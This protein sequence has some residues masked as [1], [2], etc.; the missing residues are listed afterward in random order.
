MR[1]L[2]R[3][4]TLFELMLAL[5]IIAGATAGVL[6]L[7]SWT[8]V[9]ADTQKEQRS[10]S[11]LVEAVR[12]VYATAPS[13]EGV[14]IDLV[15]KTSRL[16]DVERANG[17]PVS[18]FGG[19][20]TLR[21]A[22]VETADDAFAV[23]IGQLRAKDCASIIPALAGQ[24]AQV[25]TA[26]SGN[27]QERPHVVPDGAA[28]ATACAG[29]F[30]QQGNGSLTLVYYR[31][32]ATGAAVSTGPSCATSCAPRKEFQTVACPMGLVGHLSQERTDACS[33]DACP[34]PIIGSWTTV[35]SSCAAAPVLPPT[36]VVPTVPPTCV[37]HK[38]MRTL[39]CPA[40]QQGSGIVQEQVFTCAG[41]TEQVGAWTTVS[42]S[43]AP[44][45]V[46]P[47][48]PCVS[49]TISGVDAC[50]GG[51]GGQVSWT[52]SLTCSAGG[53]VM[54]G[55]KKIT[56][57]ACEPACVASGTCCRPARRAG[58]QQTVACEAGQYGQIINQTTQYS[59]C[60]T[61]T[62]V[63]VWQVPE[64][65]STGGA[66][67][68]CPVPVVKTQTQ[69]VARSQACPSGQTGAHSWQ[70]EQ[71]R[72]QTT[73]YD[74][75]PAPVTLPA[76]TVS[77]WSAWADVAGATQGESNTC[78]AG[79][80]Y[81]PAATG[82]TMAVGGEP[83]AGHVGA[84]GVVWVPVGQVSDCA[85]WLNT[86]NGT[87]RGGF[88]PYYTGSLPSP[89]AFC[90]QM[91]QDIDAL[92][93]GQPTSGQTIDSVGEIRSHFNVAAMS[94]SGPSGSGWY[95]INVSDII[96]RAGAGAAVAP[97]DPTTGGACAGAPAPAPTCA[98]KAGS[99]W[100]FM[101]TT[102]VHNCQAGY[103]QTCSDGTT[104]TPP[105][106]WITPGGAETMP[107][108]GGTTVVVRCDTTQGKALP[109]AW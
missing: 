74:C 89:T 22:T 70:Q 2:L 15:M 103:T 35:S 52:Q 73:S 45:P 98:F 24:T 19:A 105:V 14:D 49:G 99:G 20:L 36:P 28:I 30:F 6:R 92:A 83:A 42:S 5:V 7:A 96:A 32:R 94:A 67:A 13:Y 46:V 39:T 55:P 69:W 11:A 47:P 26:T 104:K 17:V 77:A 97:F 57:T 40:G 108:A 101:E 86:A 34:V 1:R 53:A 75:D 37:P 3:A 9:K 109:A 60:A 90:A 10:I 50:P 51:A 78:A 100:A 79:S 56:A 27:I 102:G 21:A 18:A 87:N 65:T 54:I 61:A 84:V 63:P 48:T 93:A 106:T 64:I 25:L 41:G 68:A 95:G 71:Q 62:A 31:P 88:W 43:C 80:C 82:V 91:L 29:A 76:P 8:A 16:D 58:A 38:E 23:Q 12:G 33:T 85:N 4:Y 72:K 59:T 81:T 66:C 107:A 44:P